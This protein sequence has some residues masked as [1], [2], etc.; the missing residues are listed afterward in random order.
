M[1]CRASQ[2]TSSPRIAATA[3]TLVELLVV[4]GIISVLIAILMPALG[5]ARRQAQTIQCGANLRS[6]GQAMQLYANDYKGRIPRDYWYDQEYQQGH[7]LWAEAFGKYVGHPLP[8]VRDLSANRDRILGPELAQ[9]GVYQ[10]PAHPDPRQPLDYVS[11]AWWAGV[12]GVSAPL[13]NVTR[14]PR[15]GQIVYLTEAGT[16]LPTDSFGI[17]DVFD[18]GHLPTTA[19]GQV[20]R[21]SRV[22]NDNRHGGRINL[23]FLDGHVDTRQFRD[24]GR[25]DFDWLFN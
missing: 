16:A 1:S 11:N 17:H 13:I 6:I 24:V 22:L 12:V 18:I 3:F 23:L 9:I 14:M 2:S 8:E 20:Q 19:G 21:F 15:T 7:I 5:A 25:R 10:C 4:I